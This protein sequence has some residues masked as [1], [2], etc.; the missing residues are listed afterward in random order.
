MQAAVQVLAVVLVLCGGSRADHTHTLSSNTNT[1]SAA[2]PPWMYLEASDGGTAKCKCGDSLDQRVLCDPATNQTYILACNCMTVSRH[3][4]I[5]VGACPYNCFRLHDHN[6]SIIQKSLFLYYEVPRDLS[7][8]NKAMCGHV[9]RRGQLCGECLHNYSA[10]MYSYDLRCINC[11]FHGSDV[12]KFVS[13]TL[14]PLP[15]FFIIVFFMRLSANSAQMK[16]FILLAQIISSAPSVRMMLIA[17]T[18]RYGPCVFTS[19]AK[20]ILILYQ[21]WNLDIFRGLIGHICIKHR[22]IDSLSAD[23][24]LALYPLV[25]IFFIYVLIELHA[26]NCCVIVFLWNPFRKCLFHCRREWDIQ[27]SIID[28]FATLILLSFMKVFA[29]SLDMVTAARLYNMQKSNNYMGLYSYYQGTV[30]LYS[31]ETFQ[32]FILPYIA[33]TLFN[34][35]P[36]LL[37]LLYPT[38]CFQ[39]FLTFCQT[40]GFRCLPLRTFMDCFQGCY[41]DGTDGGRDCRYFAALYLILRMLLGLIYTLSLNAYYFPCSLAFIVITTVTVAVVRPYKRKYAIY[42]TVDPILLLILA[43]MYTSAIGINTSTLKERELVTF[44]YAVAMLLGTL[45]LLYITLLATHRVM[46]TKQVKR[47]LKRLITAVQRK[48]EGER[49]E[50]DLPYRLQTSQNYGS[51]D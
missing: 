27:K 18:A 42:N 9:N 12:V 10:P 39:Q 51:I 33:I 21:V 32:Y 28:A 38:K 45:P 20:S 31:K 4:E 3:G 36:T 37:L 19:L 50:E 40:R 24:A 13:I 49:E 11:T 2:C 35:L 5:T 15:L 30:K 44:N 22:T 14:I 16:A 26:R 41:R 29:A 17:L 34:I 43:L 23:F 25:L 8:L 1:S 46:Q 7:Q 6:E 48:R 47:I